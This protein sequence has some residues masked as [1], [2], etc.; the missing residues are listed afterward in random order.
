MNHNDEDYRRPK[1]HNII[2]KPAKKNCLECQ[3]LSQDAQ[4]NHHNESDEN[5]KV[6]FVGCKMHPV[7]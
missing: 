5:L 2:F 1:H 7:D 6:V 3:I 4:S